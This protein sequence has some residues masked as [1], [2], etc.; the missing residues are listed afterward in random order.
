M[1]VGFQFVISIWFVHAEVHTTRFRLVKANTATSPSIKS[2][3][4]EI[5]RSVMS[6]LTYCP[7]DSECSGVH[8]E[9]I[10]AGSV[11]CHFLHSSVAESRMFDL[12]RK[13]S[14]KFHLYEARIRGQTE[15]APKNGLRIIFTQ[16][17]AY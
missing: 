13:V 12:W 1:F 10:G 15:R 5:A 4:N 3:R 7:P 14:V 6:C 16:L 9:P 17:G 2:Y 11:K 8:V